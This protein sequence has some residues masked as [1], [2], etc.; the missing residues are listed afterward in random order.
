MRD[1]RLPEK[2]DAAI[3]REHMLSSGDAVVIGVSGGPDSMALLHYLATRREELGIRELVAAHVHHGLRGEAADADESLVWEWCAGRGIA[4][5]VRREDVRAVARK[6]GMGLEEAGRQVRYAFFE[7]LAAVREPCR[8]A[9]AHTA[10]DNLETVLLHIIR[11]SSLKGLSGI[12]PVRGRV[13]RPLIDCSREEVEAYCREEGI[14]FRIDDSNGDVRYSR[15]RLRLRVT[16]ELK[17]LN[18]QAEQAVRRLADAVR[19]DDEYLWM[20]AQAAFQSV[21]LGGEE[22]TTCLHRTRLRDIP[23]A[24][25]YRVYEIAAEGE[26]EGRHLALLDRLLEQEGAVTL[27]GG[28]RVSVQRDKLLFQRA[29][30]EETPD[31]P[32]FP[33]IPGNSYEICGR[34]YTS[35]ILSLEEYEN[36]KKIHKILLKN[37]L[38][39]ASIRNVITV[40]RRLPGDRYRPV[41]RGGGKSLKKLFNEAGLPLEKRAETPVLCDAKGIV[42]VPGFGCD[43][44]VR[45]SSSTTQVLVFFEQGGGETAPLGIRD[46]NEGM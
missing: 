15:N 37:A 45:L 8:I 39:Y 31:F 43:E 27:P 34:M 1:G 44:R 23:P 11:G 33:L 20:Q 24:I 46:T 13:I 3:C 30:A 16:G 26:A 19:V 36:C 29:E 32:S 41:G 10:G 35:R 12:A 6:K 14:P 5:H 25:R 7:E 17:A 18:P 9:T 38:D 4:F 42:L 2:A 21:R 28:L 22:G 40:R